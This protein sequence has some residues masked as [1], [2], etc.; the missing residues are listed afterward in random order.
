MDMASSRPHIINNLFLNIDIAY[1]TLY[2]RPVVT[3]QRQQ[4]DNPP[5]RIFIDCENCPVQQL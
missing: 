1:L 2:F 5:P 3:R 4:M